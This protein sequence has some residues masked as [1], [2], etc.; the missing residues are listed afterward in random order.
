MTQVYEFSGLAEPKLTETC[1]WLKAVSLKQ[2]LMA[3]WFLHEYQRKD[4]SKGIKNNDS[5]FDNKHIKCETKNNLLSTWKRAFL[6]MAVSAF[7]TFIFRT[8]KQK[9]CPH[10]FK[11]C[12]PNNSFRFK[13][14]FYYFTLVNARRFNS[15][16]ETSWTGKK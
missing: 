16:R 15:S 10:N 13:S 7:T 11:Y 5:K 4:D 14:D 6:R 8:L 3:V 2:R 12:Y 1:I 9:G